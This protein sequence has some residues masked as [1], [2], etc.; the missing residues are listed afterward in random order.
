[1]K[2]NELIKQIVK[3]SG[4][5]V[6]VAALNMKMHRSTYAR[7]M[8]DNSFSLAEFLRLAKS[9]GATIQLSFP[10]SNTNIVLLPED[11]EDADKEKKTK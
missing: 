2:A 7:K 5:K 1:M 6:S 3:V 9:A 11:I 10:E 4:M 8:K